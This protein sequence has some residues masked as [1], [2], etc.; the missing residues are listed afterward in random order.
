MLTVDKKCEIHLLLV[1]VNDPVV[2]ASVD[3][4]M[5]DSAFVAMMAYQLY[6]AEH[7]V[8]AVAMIASKYHRRWPIL[9]SNSSAHYISICLDSVD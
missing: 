7:D 8:I 4:M 3:V 6:L 5:M 1:V 9:Y 2:L